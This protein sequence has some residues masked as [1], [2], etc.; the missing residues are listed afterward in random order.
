M[1]VSARFAHIARDLFAQR[2]HRRKLDFVAQAM[3]E[4]NL[5]FGVGRQFDGMKVQEMAFNRK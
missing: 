4:I 1:E 2:I 3:Q 5:D